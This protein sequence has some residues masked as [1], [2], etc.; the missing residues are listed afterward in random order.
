MVNYRPHKL[1]FLTTNGCD[2]NCE[3]CGI[4]KSNQPQKLSLETMHNYIDQAKRYGIKSASFTGGEPLLLG[5][6]LFDAISYAHKAG[7][8]CGVVT[9]GS[10]AKDEETGKRVAKKFFDS[11][12]DA[13]KVSMDQSHF[14]F[15]P[16]EH[17]FNAF[18]GAL[19]YELSPNINVVDLRST[20][21][22]NWSMLRKI[23]ED[24]GGEFE[25]NFI[26]I[27]GKKVAYYDWSLA[28]RQ[29]EAKKLDKREF[30]FK[31]IK[32]NEKCESQTV[33]VRSDGKVAAPCCTF[34]S[35]ANDFYVMGDAKDTTIEE[36]VER[37]NN[38]VIGSVLIGPFGVGRIGN[39]LAYAKDHN[40]R[41]LINKNYTSL[42]E[43][44]G[45]VFSDEKATK[46]IVDKFEKLK[47]SNPRVVFKDRTFAT[48]ELL[49]KVVL[50]D[51]E[52]KRRFVTFL[53]PV[54]KEDY[55]IARFSHDLELLEGMEKEQGQMSEY[56]D[57][58]K[59]SI[60][61]LQQEKSKVF[62]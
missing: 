62:H 24:L 31:K 60:E 7:M 56:T 1:A 5:E 4:Q 48:S 57:P 52:R 22:R 11:G 51:E 17:S 16:Y 25:N 44:C 50:D 2:A 42:C 41:K 37:A 6:D 40:I 19:Q 34:E 59:M 26:V 20:N 46:F 32:F 3:Y 30:K 39:A 36:V 55:D 21:F 47:D 58:L 38:S 8:F 33:T 29:G 49:A 12:L 13:L 15:V 18:K 35:A 9:N 53:G 45:T 61:V 27:N 28:S 23:V 43:F 54:R 14:E 10:Y